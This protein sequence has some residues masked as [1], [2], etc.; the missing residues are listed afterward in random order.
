MSK[1]D[2]ILKSIFP[3]FAPDRGYSLQDCNTQKKS[4]LDSMM[5]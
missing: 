3:P 4:P 2:T 1:W 5:P